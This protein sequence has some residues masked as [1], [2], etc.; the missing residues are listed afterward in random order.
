METRVAMP[1][2]LL[3][4]PALLASAGFRRVVLCDHQILSESGPFQATSDPFG[5][6]GFLDPNDLV[7]IR[8]LLDQNP[9]AP[10]FVGIIA[11]E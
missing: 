4:V 5:G 11:A 9:F 7:L 6:K 8:K 10:K 3:F 2:F 1:P